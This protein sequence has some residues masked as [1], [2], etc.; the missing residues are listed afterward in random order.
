MNKREGCVLSA[1]TGLMLVNEFEDLHAYIEEI[2]GRPVM[3]HELASDE[4]S[5]KIKAA[6]QEEF[7]T[8]INSQQ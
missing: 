8:I 3:T 1:H 7:L 6:S 2:L 4:L 5:E